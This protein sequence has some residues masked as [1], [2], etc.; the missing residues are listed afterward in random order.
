MDSVCERVCVFLTNS[1]GLRG[2]SVSH[3]GG[4]RPVGVQLQATHLRA[5]VVDQSEPQMI[6]VMSRWSLGWSVVLSL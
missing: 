4:G 2:V 3:V 6:S 5:L 1:L